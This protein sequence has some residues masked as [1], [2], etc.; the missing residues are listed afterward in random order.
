MPKRKKKTDDTSNGDPFL[1]LR[2]GG[3]HLTVQH[4]PTGLLVILA[5]LSGS[6]V[7]GW[8]VAQ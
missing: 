5:A 4:A 7:T 6:G 3:I 2:V 8:L 1:E